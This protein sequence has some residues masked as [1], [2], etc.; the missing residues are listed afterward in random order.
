MQIRCSSLPLVSACAAAVVKPETRIESSRDAA[1]LGTA[2]HAC[3]AAAC[4]G[5]PFDVD[6]V[7][8]E[9][10][11]E[12]DDL[13]PMVGWAVN[14]W[15]ERL[16][17]MFPDPIVEEWSTVTSPEFSLT[18]TPDLIAL[19]D[20][21]IRGLDWKSGWGDTDAS[22]Q[23]RGY[24]FLALNRWTEAE[25]VRFTILRV[26]DQRADTLVWT[27]KQ[28]ESWQEWLQDH[29]D[30]S[31]VYRPGEHCGRCPRALECPAHSRQI[32][33]LANLAPADAIPWTTPKDL[34]SGV[35]LARMAVK[36]L[37]EFQQA[38]KAHVEA[39]GGEFGSLYL[40]QRE[41]RAIDYA[42]GHER[43]IE[44]IGG[45]AFMQ[46]VRVSKSEVEE[47]VKRDAP[48]GQKGKVVKALMDALESDGAIS[49]TV[50]TQLKVRRENGDSNIGNAA[51]ESG[52]PATSEA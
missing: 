25:T 49:V 17:A 4:R 44:A 2:F 30:D 33:A 39:N 23:M 43:I 19:A 22:A 21:E 13:A 37:E 11:V 31:D 32:S 27:R 15:R 36:R 10:N 41:T 7:A 9:Q 47:A 46:C 51:I 50:S 1:D 42:R 18:G 8:A 16:A 34:A 48:R 3:M 26:R 40:D 5:E 38:A 35:Q 28:I 14:L 6:A 24:A 45:H 29:L 52:E 12:V 20:G